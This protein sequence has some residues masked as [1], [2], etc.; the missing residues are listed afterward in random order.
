MPLKMNA[1]PEVKSV[2]HNERRCQMMMN[3][4]AVMALSSM[5]ALTITGGAVRA[6]DLKD[7]PMSDKYQS[8]A[9]VLVARAMSSPHEVHFKNRQGHGVSFATESV[10]KGV[11]PAKFELV[12]SGSFTDLNV[13]C[14]VPGELY[15]L[16]LGK[17]D[18]TTFV[19]VRGRFG[20]Y[21]LSNHLA[22]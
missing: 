6:F 3:R 2:C 21:R 12:I 1:E 4:L 5:I 15:L 20:V 16:Y 9:V 8:A 22:E 10:M 19:S 13:R 14:C 18:E 7:V 11:A 17:I